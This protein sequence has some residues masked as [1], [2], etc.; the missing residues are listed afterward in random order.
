MARKPYWTHRREQTK[1]QTHTCACGWSHTNKRSIEAHAAQCRWKP[2]E[3]SEDSSSED[4]ESHWQDSS[5][6]ESEQDRDDREAAACHQ[7][8]YAWYLAVD[9]FDVNVIIV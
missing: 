4:S 3:W 9:H 2:A 8:F 5:D 1:N 6:G 7:H